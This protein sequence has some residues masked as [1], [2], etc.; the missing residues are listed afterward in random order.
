MSKY[1]K[2][3]EPLDCEWIVSSGS[4]CGLSFS[5]MNTFTSHVKDHM[6][7][8]DGPQICQW[9]GCE[10]SCSDSQTFAGHVLFHPYHSYQKL[11]GAEYQRRLKL[12]SC[13][14]DGDTRN[15]I[16]AVEIE[17]MC[18]WNDSQCGKIFQSVGEFYQHT[19]EHIMTDV[20]TNC[21]W[22]GLFETGRGNLA[23][24]NI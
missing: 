22:K 1:C 2:V 16:P 21:L 18:L 13:Q 9:I 6:V 19:H 8:T 11:L 24:W 10:F 5:N 23:V 15:L 7:G 4:A 17:L 12:P 3:T 20:K 14:M